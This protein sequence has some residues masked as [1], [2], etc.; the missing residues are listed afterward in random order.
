VYTNEHE[1]ECFD[2]RK[3]FQKRKIKMSEAGAAIV[4]AFIVGTMMGIGLATTQWNLIIGATV[5]LFI[6]S[7]YYHRFVKSKENEHDL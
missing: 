1:G 7:C 2:C 5:L 3:T 4:L 6:V